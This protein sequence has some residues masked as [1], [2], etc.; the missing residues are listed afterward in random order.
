MFTMSNVAYILAVIENGYTAWDKIQEKSAQ[1]GQDEDSRRNGDG[2]TRIV[3][4]KYTSH[5]GSKRQYSHSG[6]NQNRMDFYD[7]VK[8]GWKK[9]S[10]KNI[11]NV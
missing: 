4:G 10:S 11:D 9:L 2:N 1:Q 5:S 6:W 3:K 7:R 8:M